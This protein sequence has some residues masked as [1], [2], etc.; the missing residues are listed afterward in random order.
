M[1]DKVRVQI[2][3]FVNCRKI[4]LDAENIYPAFLRVQCE[5]MIRAGNFSTSTHLKGWPK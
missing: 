5:L 2:L 4:P 3:N 1:E